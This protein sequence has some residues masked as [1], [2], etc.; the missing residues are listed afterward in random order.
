MTG[1]QPE[2]SAFP[3]PYATIVRLRAAHTPEEEVA[4]AVGLSRK[5]MWARISRWNYKHPD[6]RIPA[7]H[8]MARRRNIT[9]SVIE[10]HEQGVPF[11]EMPLR[12]GIASSSVYR[13]VH[14]ARQSG[15][16]P[17]VAPP[18]LDKRNGARHWYAMWQ[19]DPRALRKG[20]IQSILHGLSAR[21]V[22]K[23]LDLA[24]RR[25]TIVISDL[26]LDILKE[27]LNASTPDR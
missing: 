14:R 26:I 3:E 9:T 13:A 8:S 27:H 4:T 18:D 15:R 1:E 22:N 23:L 17:P 5:D 20:S 25:G 6:Q 7:P 12:L 24:P 11:V 21:E 19:K 10:L 2:P 16:L